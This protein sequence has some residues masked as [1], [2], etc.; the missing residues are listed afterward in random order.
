MRHDYEGKIKQDNFCR[1]AHMLIKQFLENLTDVFIN[2]ACFAYH[3]I[4]KV[5]SRLTNSSILLL[6]TSSVIKASGNKLLH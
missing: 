1:K 4:S 5:F 2:D 3:T 6:K